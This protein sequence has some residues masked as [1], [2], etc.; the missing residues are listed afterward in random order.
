MSNAAT[1]T[2]AEQIEIDYRRDLLLV[3]GKIIGAYL[4]AWLATMA[5]LSGAARLYRRRARR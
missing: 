2:L 1:G 3:C 4:L 5:L